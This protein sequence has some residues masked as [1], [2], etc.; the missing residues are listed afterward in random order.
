MKTVLEIRDEV[1]VRFTGLD[2]KTR[3]KISDAC[4]YM[5][6]YAYHMPAYKLGRWDGCIRFCDIGGRTYF[7]LLEKL[8]PIITADG[9][10][11]EVVDHRK[12]WDFKFNPVEQTSYD[13]VAW[14]KK[15]PA[16][17]TPI[18]L[19]DYQVDIINTFL[20]NPQCVQEIA[21]GA[22]KTL[23]TAV[24]SQKCEEYGRT[25]VIVPNKDLVV[26]TEKDYK[27]LGLDV[28]VLFGDRKEYDKTHTICTWQSLAVM[29]KK[30]KAGD[31]PFPIDEF[32][33]GVVCIMVDE[34]HKA[35]ADV[36][37]DLLSGAFKHVPIRWG[38]TGTIPKDEYEAVGCVCSLG[39]VEGKMGSKELQDMGVLAQL[40]INVFQLQDG[41]LGFGNYAQELK[42]L[43]TDPTRI[44]HIGE[45]IT[46]LAVNGNTLVLIDRI[47]TGEQLA[48][49][50]EDWVFVSGSMKQ[51]DR[52][53]EYDEI[54][55]AD[56]KVIV[57][58]YGV[59]SVGINIPRI[60]NLVMLEPGKSFVRVVQSIGRG[61]RKASDKDYL[62][63]VD[64]T[65]NL[66]YSK[67]HLTKRKAF[68]K[69]QGFP[70]KVTKV[71]YK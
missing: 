50:H 59:A 24:L 63:V 20:K 66:K 71:E 35:K 70:F 69:D 60:F 46:G 18:I 42:W 19:R 16:E 2:V 26:Q 6:P 3:R 34:V 22:G 52:Q 39:P 61:I 37:R 43:V 7:H 38:L 65:S 4:K 49:L 36:L 40:D 67:R 25:I 68:Y 8:L 29:E 17:G 62:N 9:Y 5:L 31:T 48:E 41:H 33:D 27:N 47:A 13:H 10:E 11:I 30:T 14:P 51:K 55:D 57:A 32:L 53:T 45:I 44:K 54:S 58:T 15:H 64:I 28:G 1:N 21:T 12:K 56:N 23:V